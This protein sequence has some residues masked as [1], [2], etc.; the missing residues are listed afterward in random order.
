MTEDGF[1]WIQQKNKFSVGE[2]IEIMK[3]DGRNVA[4]QV[5]EIQNQEGE[6]MTSA[7][8]PQQNLRI[9]LEIPPDPYDILRRQEPE[10]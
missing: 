3:P 7:P 9:K 2:E 4:A 8:H 1:A 6:Q 10:E 5:L